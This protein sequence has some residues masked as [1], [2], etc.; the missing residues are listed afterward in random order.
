MGMT[1]VLAE[2]SRKV[3][4]MTIHSIGEVSRLQRVRDDDRL[5][6][7]PIEMLRILM[8]DNRDL[9]ERMRTAHRSVKKLATSP[10]PVSWRTSS[11]SRSA[12]PG[13]YTRRPWAKGAR[14]GCDRLRERRLMKAVVYEGTRQVSVEDVPDARRARPGRV[15]THHPRLEEAPEVFERFDRREDGIIKAVFRLA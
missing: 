6:V 3:G 10:R 9:T 12:E 4:Q 14:R 13:S 1:D 5:F 7:E 2:R 8:A 11:T 15:V